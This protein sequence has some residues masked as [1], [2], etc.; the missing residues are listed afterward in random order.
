MILPSS[1]IWAASVLPEFLIFAISS[2]Y[3]ASAALASASPL[4]AD[5]VSYT[6]LT[7]PTKA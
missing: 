5:A 7:L 1:R 2:R 4:M 3:D 6:H